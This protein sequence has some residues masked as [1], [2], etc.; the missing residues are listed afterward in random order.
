[1][2]TPLL[3][4]LSSID[5][6]ALNP[7]LIKFGQGVLVLVIG[8]IIV[9]ALSGIISGVLK[10]QVEDDSLRG[11]LSS[12]I[13]ILLKIC[14]VIA[15]ANTAGVEATSFTVLLGSA[16]LAVGMA[17]S[18]TLQNFAGGVMIILFKPFKVGD[19]IEAQGYVGSVK[20]IQIFQTQLTTPDNKLIII[21][22]GPLSNGALT[23]FSA[24]DKRRVDHVF[25]IGY[26]DDIDLAR[27]TIADLIAAD[28][29][30]LT[31]EDVTI[32]VGELADSSVNFTVRYWVLPADYWGSY[33]DLLES[34]KKTFDAK[35]ISI[36][37]PQMDV[38]Q[39]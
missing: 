34:V 39:K 1:M 19:V 37:Y 8:F 13:S 4:S 22:N 17:L 5:L 21:P 12:I 16:G 28:K 2:K 38:H 7:Y 10:K 25:G 23:N 33:F 20:D 11:F 36:P 31:T 6:T 18:G 27:Q 30:V 3:T 24:M 9:K 32:V 35:K 14:V 26:D 15:A 29:R